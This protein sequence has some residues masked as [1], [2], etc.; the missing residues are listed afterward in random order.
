[1]QEERTLVSFGWAINSLLRDKANY[2]ILEGFLTTLLGKE[3]KIKKITESKNYEYTKDGFNRVDVLAEE[4]DGTLIIIELQFNVEMDY[5]HRMLF[6]SSKNIAEHMGK[7]VPY[8]KVKKAYSVNMV[9]FDLGSGKDY[10]YHG[11]TTLKGLHCNDELKLTDKE[12]AEFAGLKIKDICLEY[13]FLKPN[14]FKNSIKNN[15]DEWMY[16]LTNMIIKPKFKAQGLAEAYERFDFHRLSIKER[17]AY[18]HYIDSC[19]SNE[20]TIY[21]AKLERRDG[22]AKHNIHFVP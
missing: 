15:I 17:R 2:V 4:N 1:M 5:Y 6:G 18:E 8:S 10:I 22:K 12:K 14:H 20:S 3:I 16:F 13:Y 9:Y 7:G 11:T 21:T 19:R